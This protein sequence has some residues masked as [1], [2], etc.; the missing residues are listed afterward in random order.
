[1]SMH[2]RKEP[3]TNAQAEALL[4]S[5]ASFRALAHR[6]AKAVMGGRVTKAKAAE[7]AVAAVAVVNE[8]SP[9]INPGHYL[10][11]A[12]VLSFVTRFPRSAARLDQPDA[13]WWL[14]FA[15]QFVNS[16]GGIF[17]RG[18]LKPLEMWDAVFRSYSDAIAPY[19][20]HQN[21]HPHIA[22]SKRA[23]I[24]FRV[25]RIVVRVPAGAKMSP[26][27]VVPRDYVN[28]S[29]GFPNEK[30]GEVH[31]GVT[32]DHRDVFLGSTRKPRKVSLKKLLDSAPRSGVS[33]KFDYPLGRKVAAGKLPQRFRG[34]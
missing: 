10:H 23:A 26:V 19:F 17:G 27:G 8:V 29:L 28:F 13:E 7:A 32:A 24:G 5:N 4:K 18:S 2:W 3:W 21:I 1:M 25:K 20:F 33:P 9:K 14:A 15:G 22:G 34:L 12:D 6:A 30:F 16:Y 11:P 31:V